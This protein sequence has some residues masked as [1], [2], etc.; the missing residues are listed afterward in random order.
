MNLKTQVTLEDWPFEINYQS[1]ILSLGSCFSQEIGQKLSDLKL[2][3]I[4]NP[5]GITFN[6]LS[7]LSCIK[8]C[9]LDDSLLINEII[10]SEELYV[11]PDFH[12]KFNNTVKEKVN[13]NIQSS[14]QVLRKVAQDIDNVILTIGTS[15][16][17]VKKDTQK[18]VNN[19]HKLPQEQ[20][21][22]VLLRVEQIFEALQQIKSII[23]DKSS[24]EVNFIITLSPVRHLRDGLIQNQRS[25]ARALEAIHQFSEAHKNVYY[26]PSYEILIDELRDYRFYKEDM[27][28]PSPL[29]VQ[30]IYQAFE[31]VVLSDKEASLR[32]ELAT[33]VN[34]YNHKPLHP[35]SI[36]HREFKHKLVDK[37]KRIQNQYAAIDFSKEIKNL[38]SQA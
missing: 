5:C 21:D 11:H 36:N 6:P 18:V 8:R 34:S 24:K 20:F 37:M 23:E 27:I 29:A 35:G 14:L 30:Y 10:K 38:K 13:Y 22:R 3:I 17:F 26:F 33:L 2:S 32:K 9:Y 28:H 25:K 31:A 15:W 19:C 7:M 1:K 16:V 4:Q 12:G